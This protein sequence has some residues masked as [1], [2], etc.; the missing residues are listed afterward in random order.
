M[1]H[2]VKKIAEVLP[3]HRLRLVFDAGEERILDMTPLIEEGGIWAPLGDDS[4]FARVRILADE[5]TGESWEALEWPLEDISPDLCPDVAYYLSKP[6][7]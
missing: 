1:G 6:T 3:E 2:A 4:L 7:N 5:E